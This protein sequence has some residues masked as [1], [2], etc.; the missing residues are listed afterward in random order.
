M[1]I[2]LENTV[3]V[4]VSVPGAIGMRFI[5]MKMG[6]QRGRRTGGTEYRCFGFKGI[7]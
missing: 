7:G 3:G 1:S 5:Y 4:N 2:G 6:G